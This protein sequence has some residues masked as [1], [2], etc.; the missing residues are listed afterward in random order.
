MAGK[1][2]VNALLDGLMNLGIGRWPANT[3]V[4]QCHSSASAKQ[5]T[6]LRIYQNKM[7]LYVCP[8]LG[9]RQIFVRLRLLTF[10]QAAL[11]PAPDFFP[12]SSGSLYFFFERLRGAKKTGSGLLVKFG[13]IFFSPQTSR[14]K[15]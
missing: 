10:F 11:A 6:L 9:S 7:S 1:F 13:Q 14:Q 15:I 3:L 4:P 5:G 12:S 2:F 8:G